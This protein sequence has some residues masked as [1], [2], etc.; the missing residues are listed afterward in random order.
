[1]SSGAFKNINYKLLVYKFYIYKDDLVLNNL[2]RLVYNKTQ[3]TQS[4]DQIE[5]LNRLLF[6]KLFVSKQRINIKLKN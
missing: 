6:V 4:P 2:Q 1:M 5:L 3:P